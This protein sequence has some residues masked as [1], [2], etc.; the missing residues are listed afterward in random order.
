MAGEERK[1]EL[2]ASGS[3]ESA[4]TPP[5]SA[6]EFRWQAIFQKSTEP[7][8]LLNRHRRIL[9]VNKAWERLT[10]MSGTEARGLACARRAPDPQDPWDLA[11]RAL[12][13][14]TPE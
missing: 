9:F 5:A 14:P 2:V 1:P 8:F 11:V 3:E 4:Q 7:L 10:G 13:Y 12:C 6:Q